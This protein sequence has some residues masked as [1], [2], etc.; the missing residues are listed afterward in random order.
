VGAGHNE[1]RGTRNS[2]RGRP[3]IKHVAILSR[4]SMANE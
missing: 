1:T 3:K 4:K 2:K